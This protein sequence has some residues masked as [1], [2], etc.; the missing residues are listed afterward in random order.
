[1]YELKQVEC[2]SN[3]KIKIKLHPEATEILFENRRY[4]KNVFSN[5]QG[6]Y[7]ITH[8]G[9]GVTGTPLRARTDL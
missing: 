9:M 1:M 4:I 6:L 8:M 5:L 7:G 2:Q 3:Q